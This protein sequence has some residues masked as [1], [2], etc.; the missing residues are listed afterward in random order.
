MLPPTWLDPHGLRER[1]DRAHLVHLLEAQDELSV[2]GDRSARQPRAA[3]R[4][5]DGDAMLAAELEQAGDL[6]GGA[7][8]RDRG[9]IGRENLG[10][11]LP[12]GQEILLGATEEVGGKGSGDLGEEFFGQGGGKTGGRHS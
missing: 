11:V 5:H 6:V 7:G 8:K 3:P 2:R 1:V 4:R 10:P 9:G 12:V